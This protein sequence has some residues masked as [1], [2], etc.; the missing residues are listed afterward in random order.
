MV[1]EEDGYRHQGG[2]R[3]FFALCLVSWL[4]PKANLKLCSGK[5]RHFLKVFLLSQKY[6]WAFSKQ[7]FRSCAQTDK[8]KEERA[9]FSCETTRWMMLLQLFSNMEVT[10]QEKIECTIS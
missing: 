4:G 6:G 7:Y 10:L 2:S 8:N 3:L 9:H 5:S 1:E